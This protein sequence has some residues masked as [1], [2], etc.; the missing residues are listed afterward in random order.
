[1]DARDL[2]T[3]AFAEGLRP[4][5]LYWATE[6]LLPVLEQVLHR[7]KGWRLWKR[8]ALRMVISALHQLLE[9]AP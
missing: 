3:A 1:V 4:Q 5:V 7:S 2:R 6:V 9:E 8:M